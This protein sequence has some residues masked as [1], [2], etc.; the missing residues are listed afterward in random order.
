MT[1]TLTTVPATAPRQANRAT[2]TI[3]RAAIAEQNCSVDLPAKTCRVPPRADTAESTLAQP[4]WP[5]LKQR[6]IHTDKFGPHAVAM[7]VKRQSTSLTSS[8]TPTTSTITKH[9]VTFKFH[10]SSGCRGSGKAANN[11]VL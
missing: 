3:T 9:S 1:V 10:T 4:R 5:K 7:T 8:W 6:L 2:A 11:E